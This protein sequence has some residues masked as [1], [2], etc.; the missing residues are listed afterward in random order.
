M[1]YSEARGRLNQMRGVFFVCSLFAG[2]LSFVG[3]QWWLSIVWLASGACAVGGD[4]LKR[5]RPDPAGRAGDESID[6]DA[7]G[8]LNEQA[9]AA[10]FLRLSFVIGVAVLTSTL[11]FKIAWV[12]SVL[13]ALTA[14]F[15]SMLLIPLLCISGEIIDDE[16][17]QSP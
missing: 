11:A 6:P 2:L 8:G 5:K 12:A 9:F 7:Q 16:E 15:F 3:Q 17:T 14:W 10:E 4:R 13:L 1:R